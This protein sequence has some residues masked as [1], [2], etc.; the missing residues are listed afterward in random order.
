MVS[1]RGNAA[2]VKYS[3]V[4]AMGGLLIER[5]DTRAAKLLVWCGVT[6]H[7]NGSVLF[8]SSLTTLKSGKVKP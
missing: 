7:Y 3:L 2:V 4:N 1:R 5:Q 6:Q 8:S